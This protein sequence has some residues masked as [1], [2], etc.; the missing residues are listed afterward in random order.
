MRYYDKITPDGTRDLLFGECDQRSQVTKTLVQAANACP[1]GAGK[2][3]EE[4]CV[5]SNEPAAQ[6]RPTPDKPLKAADAI[7]RVGV[8]LRQ[9]ASSRCASAPRRLWFTW[10][11]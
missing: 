1:P 6:T 4:L 7:A 8:V 10:A 9:N 5:L 2:V 11:A 3:F